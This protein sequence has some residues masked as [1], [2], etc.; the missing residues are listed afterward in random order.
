MRICLRDVATA[1]KHRQA[2]TPKLFRQDLQA[3]VRTETEKTVSSEDVLFT[4]VCLSCDDEAQCAAQA[5]KAAHW[6]LSNKAN[7]NNFALILIYVYTDIYVCVN[8]EGHQLLSSTVLDMDC[9]IDQIQTSKPALGFTR[10]S[11]MCILHF[12]STAT[13]GYIRYTYHEV[14]TN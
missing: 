12:L 13:Q 9:I 3:V 14:M 10:F 5:N 4:C 11:F 7:A 8:G 1:T 2:A 6:D